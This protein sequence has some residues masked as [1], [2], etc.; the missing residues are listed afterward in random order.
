MAFFRVDIKSWLRSGALV[1]QSW[2]YYLPAFR[3]RQV[4]YKFDCQCPC[5]KETAIAERVL[6]T[7]SIPSFIQEQ[8]VGCMNGY[9]DE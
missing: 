8:F 3:L 5:W 2:L 1:I 9:K 7:V 4:S 6:W